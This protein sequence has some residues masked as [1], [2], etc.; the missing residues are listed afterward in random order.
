MVLKL[1]L[2]KREE[3]YMKICILS[4]QNVQNAG[5]LLQSY[6][7]KKMIESMNHDVYFLPI[8]RRVEDAKL[9][10]DTNSF[11]DEYGNKK[12]Y[13][14]FKKI[15]KFFI[16]R[17]WMKLKE[18]RQCLLFDN[19]RKNKLGIKTD[20][21][22]YDIFDYCVI[23][24][25]EVFNCCDISPWGFTT[26]LFGEVK[27]ARHVISYA[28]SCG[29]T[30]ITQIPKSVRI[31]IYDAMK[32]MESISVR[33]NN[34]REFV[35]VI[36]G[37]DSKIN[38]DPVLLN[39]FS[40]E[41]KMGKMFPKIPVNYCIIYSYC[42]RIHSQKEIHAIIAFCNSHNLVPIAVGSPQMW[43]K[44]YIVADPFDIL[45]LFKNARFVITDTFHGTIFSAKYYDRFA[46]IVRVSNQN[47]LQDLIY[48]IEIPDNQVQ[49]ISLD[50]LER[51]WNYKHDKI[52]FETLITRERKNSLDYL[53]DSIKV[54]P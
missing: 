25:D 16:N 1:V 6:S 37:R 45:R 54:N 44:D 9:L 7:L 32:R 27:E 19:F 36:S 17:I 3:F 48:R 20:T 50:E 2:V 30:K 10:T 42:N 11:W 4:M 13:Q 39:D 12:Y 40:E 46:V 8:E 51:A 33:D 34:T 15:D 52:N 41:M 22:F 38:L 28:A 24:S 5:S 14:K 21:N 47:K 31:K 26:Q 29:A 23:G 18:R 53:E 43:I 35:K 49:E